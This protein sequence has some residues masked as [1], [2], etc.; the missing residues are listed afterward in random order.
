MTALDNHPS[1]KY[2]SI[3][4]RL[5]KA[6]AEYEQRFGNNQHQAA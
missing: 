6:R 1:K 5:E 3:R 4:N 2:G